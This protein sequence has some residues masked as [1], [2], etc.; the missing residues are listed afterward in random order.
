MH[1]SSAGEL[2]EDPLINRGYGKEEDD[3]DDL[4]SQRPHP[5]SEMTREEKLARIA[6]NAKSR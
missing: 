2:L 4:Q 3:G 6:P 1:D 5:L